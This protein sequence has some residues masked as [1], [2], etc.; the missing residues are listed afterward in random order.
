MIE[1]TLERMVGWM[2][3]VTRRVERLEAVEITSAGWVILPMASA[4]TS[5]DWNGN[6]RSTTAKTIIDMSAV[7]GSPENI[8]ALLLRVA[9]QDSGAGSSTAYIILSENATA[10]SGVRCV[11]YPANDRNAYFSVIVPTN[12][13]GDIYYQ[14]VATGTNTLDVG[15]VVY[16]YHLR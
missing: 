16:G 15:I 13:D 14:T 5:T 4:L 11:C 10:H 6:A 8:D 1:A 12:S 3:D 2:K 9:V 7:F